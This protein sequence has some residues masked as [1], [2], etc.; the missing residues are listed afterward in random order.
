MSGQPPTQ[1]RITTIL[2]HEKIRGLRIQESDMEGEN[3]LM[4]E[5]RRMKRKSI[6]STAADS[7]FS[8][9]F[10]RAVVIV[11]L[12]SAKGKHKRQIFT[13]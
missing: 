13:P 4:G 11:V 10:F 8:F 6:Y 5:K 7:D 9:P 3:I 2:A 12:R 1:M